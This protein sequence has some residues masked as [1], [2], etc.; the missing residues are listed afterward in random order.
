MTRT[1]SA[2]ALLLSAIL[3]V[4]CSS[5]QGSRDYTEHGDELPEPHLDDRSTMTWSNA[6]VID[7]HYVRISFSTTQKPPCM[8]YDAV[9][10]EG[11]ES[12]VITLFSG[13]TIRSGEQCD[14]DEIDLLM[15]T[16]HTVGVTIESPVQDR[17]IIDGGRLIHAEIYDD[18]SESAQ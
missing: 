3:L 12:I 18:G 10:E 7:D 11:N 4:G 15:A 14:D 1:N 6:E 13:E 2:Y 9:V 5:D 16:T 8:R 17:E